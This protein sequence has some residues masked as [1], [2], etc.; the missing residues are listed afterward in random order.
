MSE[1]QYRGE[2]ENYT[3]IMKDNVIEVWADFES[4]YP[5][6]YIYLKEGMVNNKKEFEIEIA[7]WWIRNKA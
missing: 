4:E 7:S 6:T 2:I 3:F 5:E 1:I